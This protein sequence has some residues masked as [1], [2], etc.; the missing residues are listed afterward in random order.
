MKIIS[1]KFV[2]SIR[3]TDSILFNPIPQI[4]FV[5]RSNVGKS[6]LINCL[7]NS[8]SLV[9]SGK[10]PGKTQE[11]NFFL[12]NGNMHFVDLPGYGFSKVKFTK[13]EQFSK[14]IQWY[15]LEPILKRKVVFVLDARISPSDL[16]LEMYRILVENNQEVIIAA[17]KV[18]ALTQKEC[19]SNLK[20]ITESF[21]Y[22]I[23]I[24][25]SAKTKL[26]REEIW[27]KITE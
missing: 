15:L 17:N 1:A 9:K 16:D 6:S 7:L 12:V 18:D 21:P 24:P 26:G 25:C 5:G 19:H 10:K 14:M 13:R 22:S 2:K 11:I 27:K 23:I 4:A 3:G 8:N 20:A